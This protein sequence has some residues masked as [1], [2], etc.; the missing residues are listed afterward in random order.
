LVVRFYNLERKGQVACLQFG[1]PLK[2][3]Y[4]LNLNEERQ[5]E[6]LALSPQ[7][8]L[9]ITTRPAEVVTLELVVR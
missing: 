8:M 4:R 7:G 2:A 5:G 3:V 6:A 9:E 1:L